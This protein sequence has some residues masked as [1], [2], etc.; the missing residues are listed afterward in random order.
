MNWKM[1]HSLEQLGG[2]LRAHFEVQILHVRRK[3][4]RLVDLMANYGATKKQ[5]LQQKKWE[6]TMEGALR[7][8]CQK[9][10]EQDQL[11]PECG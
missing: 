6:D 4:N 11:R 1:T 10:M 3:S 2:L 8:E 5:E 7:R 9:I